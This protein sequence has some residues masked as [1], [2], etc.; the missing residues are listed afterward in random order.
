MI[1]A[2]GDLRQVGDREHLHPLAELLHQAADGLGDRA[3]DAGIDLIEDQRAGAAVLLA[4]GDGDGQRDAREL[5]ARGDLGQRAR[6]AAG[7]A[8]DEELGRL[9]PEALR[10]VLRQQRDL[11]AA[12]GHAELLHRLRHRVRQRRRRLGARGADGLGFLLVALERVGLA[13]LQRIEVGGGVELRELGLPFREQR[14]QLGRLAAIAAGERDPGGQ[15][16][17]ELPQPVRIEVGGMQVGAEAVRG[18]LQLGLRAQQRVDGVLQPGVVAEHVLQR[19]QRFVGQRLGVDLGLGDTLQRAARGVH[20]RLRMRQALV[21]RVEFVPL[22]GT[23]REAVDLA[24][25]PAQALMLARQVGLFGLRGAHR[26][27]GLAP[28]AEGG[29]HRPGLDLGEAVQQLAHAGRAGQAL[30]GVLAVDVEQMLGQLA[31]LGDG[32]GAAVDPRAALALGVD[33]AAQQQRVLGAVGGVEAG[34][35][36]PGG[37][38]GGAVELGRDL[39]AG[40]ALAHDG[41]VAARAQGQLQRVDQDGLARAGLAGEGGETGGEVQLQRRDDDEVLEAQAAQHQVFPS[42]QRSLR[43]SVA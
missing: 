2:G 38:G 3:A 19:G 42:F 8:G 26:L 9:H 12:A 32:G 25:L 11:E 17:V 20:Q 15:A 36:Q 14:R 6:R 24:D 10:L 31:Q 35:L 28:L 18:V 22:V 41:G 13:G 7:V 37:E 29:G 43:R 21:L 23:G 16:V 34:F 39:G 4:G 27:A 30:P 1:G 40:G 33:D 5:A